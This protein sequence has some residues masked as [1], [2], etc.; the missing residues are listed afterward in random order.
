[1]SYIFKSCPLA[2]VVHCQDCEMLAL[3][4]LKLGLR[5]QT[6]QLSFAVCGRVSNG[7]VSVT[8]SSP[9]IRFANSKCACGIQD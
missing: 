5:K 8:H 2:C 7:I 1:M 6:Q 9:P 4:T 3:L